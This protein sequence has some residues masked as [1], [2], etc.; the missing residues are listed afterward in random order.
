MSRIQHLLPAGL[1]AAVGIWVCYVSF[2][3]QPADA[4]LFP[5]LISAAF[6]VLSLFTL[7]QTALGR[8]EPG[9]GLGA[10]QVINLLPGF[11]VMLVYVFWAAKTLG[12]YTATV[13]AFFVVLSLYDPGSHLNPR[14]WVR[15]LLVTAVFMAVMYGLF[16][17]LLRVFTPR[18]IFF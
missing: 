15:R 9:G 8:S 17:L 10:E 18:E 3:Q 1:I 13:I 5:R 16:A 2:T 6:V 12:F 7:L 14:V 11:I 4:F